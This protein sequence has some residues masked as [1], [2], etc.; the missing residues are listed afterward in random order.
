MIVYDILLAMVLTVA[1]LI[2]FTWLSWW[3]VTAPLWVIPAFMALHFTRGL[4]Y[5]IRR[6]GSAS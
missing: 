2:H 5:G 6:G 3:V 4:V 1:K